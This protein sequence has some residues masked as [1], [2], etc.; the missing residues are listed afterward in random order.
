MRDLRHWTPRYV[1]D[2]TRELIYQRTHPTAPW[3]TPEATRLL[4]T[5]L[6]P[7]D[8]GLE[9]GSGRSTAWLATMVAHLTSVEHD[10]SWHATVLADLKEHQRDNVDYLFAPRDLPPQR[11]AET[12]YVAVADR[13]A[14]DSLDFVLVDGIYRDFCALAALTRLRSGGLL[15]VDNVNWFLPSTSRSPA[16]RPPAAGA[17]GPIWT[18]TLD[19]L[20]T[21]RMIWTSNGVW[22]TAIFVK[23]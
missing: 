3:L 6:R 22:D 2:R 15:I 21:W 16:S 7:V 20:R 23:P 17:D 4:A 10:P 12:E 8:H 1:F 13:F 19:A 9:F 18:Q 14:P 5:M 11:G